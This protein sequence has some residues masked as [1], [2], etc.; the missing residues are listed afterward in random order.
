MSEPS[1]DKGQYPDGVRICSP[2]AAPRLPLPLGSCLG[3]SMAQQRHDLLGPPFLLS[4]CPPEMLLRT[5]VTRGR[6]ITA[7]SSRANLGGG[8]EGGSV[9]WS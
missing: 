3:D 2:L 1:S 7:R 6:P 5:V 8:F 4:A 9:Q